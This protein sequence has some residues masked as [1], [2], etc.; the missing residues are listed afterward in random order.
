[1]SDAIDEGGAPA[2]MGGGGVVDESDRVREGAAQNGV[3]PWEGPVPEDPRL[4]PELLA[5]GDRRN[6][7]DRYRYWTMDAIRADIARRALPFEV[8]V[9][10]PGH[11][12]NIGSIV[13]T[14]NALGASRVHIVGRRR[15][16]RRG[17]MVTDRYLEVD[18]LEDAAALAASCAQRDLVLVGVDNV[19]GA[20][21]LETTELPARACL[22]FGEESGG[23]SAQ[24]L[25]ECALVVRVSQRGSTRSMNV[26]HAAA[27]VMWAHARSL[28]EMRSR[29]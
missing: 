17:A 27:I 18:H 26:G 15:W 10:N 1:M 29:E 25:A 7:E 4:D 20:V 9:G 3:G 11:D 23:L 16:N 21:P 19:E 14:A 6:V 22:V 8:A 12:F 28:E 24:M 13:R 2:R 5:H